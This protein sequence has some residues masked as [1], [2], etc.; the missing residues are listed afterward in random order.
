LGGSYE[1]LIFRQLPSAKTAAVGNPVIGNSL[2]AL[3]LALL[4]APPMLAL[5]WTQRLL[6]RRRRVDSRP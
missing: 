1:V 5:L 4:H 6:R 3:I 2:F